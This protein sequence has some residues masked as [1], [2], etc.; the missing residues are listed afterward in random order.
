[1]KKSK[2]IHLYFNSTSIGLTNRNELKIW[3]STIFLE[4]GRLFANLNF[5]FCTDD[6]L[7]SINNEFLGH[8]DYTDIITF[9]LGKTKDP[10]SGEIYIST[11]RIRDNAAKHGCTIKNE[12]QRVMAHGVLHLCGYKDKTV[13]D[14]LTMTAKENYYLNK[15]LN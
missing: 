14:K 6:F 2:N 10:I 11:E 1:M 12:I 5:I 7:L 3:L 4:E 13:K 9:S 8:D 15:R